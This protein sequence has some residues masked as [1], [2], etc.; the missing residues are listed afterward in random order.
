MVLEML[1]CMLFNC[2]TWLLAQESSVELQMCLN[3][4]SKVSVN[5]TTVPGF[6]SCD[7]CGMFTCSEL[8]IQIQAGLPKLEMSEQTVLGTNTNAVSSHKVTEQMLLLSEQRVNS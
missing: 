8:V 1:V 6:K 7:I 4:T 3:M 2:L 5:K